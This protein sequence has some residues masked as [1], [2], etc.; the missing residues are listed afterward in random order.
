M[1]SNIAWLGQDSGL[2]NVSSTGYHSYYVLTTDVWEGLEYCTVEN[3]CIYTLFLG[4][5]EFASG[6]LRK[7][8]HCYRFVGKSCVCH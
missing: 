6:H 5:W 2:Q 8:G 7:H 4:S 1:W 3:I